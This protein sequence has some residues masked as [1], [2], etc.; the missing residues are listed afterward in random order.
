MSLAVAVLMDPI[1]SIKVAKD[2]TLAMLLEAQRRGHTL[3]YMEQGDLAVR[4]GKAWARMAP[5]QVRDDPKD[6]CTLG[7]ADWRPLRDVDIVLERKD[8]P[9]DAQFIY[10][11]M[12][13]ELAEREGVRVV[14]RPQS[15]RDCNEKL[16]A[17]QFP[18]C[19]APTRVARDP[20]TLREFVSEHDQVVLKP[21]DG[22]GGRG[23]FRSHRGD[24][25]L[26][27][28]LETLTEDGTRL[29]IAQRYIPEITAG[30]KRIL[31]IDGEPVPYALARIPQG[32]EFRG[33]LAAGGRGEGVP[34]SDRDRWIVEQV[35][36]DLRRRGLTFV[37]LDVIGDY[38]TE[39]NVTS[40]TCIREL[41]AQF[42][43]TIAGLM[44]DAIEKT[45]T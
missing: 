30:D 36:P 29:A 14:N 24:P 31:V 5:L 10:D 7:N 34:L 4:D 43:L 26:N 27:S 44:F 33:N 32:D 22:M 1:Q 2:S 25:N 20:D 37:G 12:V 16:Y 9:V 13:L 8:P 23:I 39:I 15:L 21:L 35:A 40:P 17:L 28:I 11:S 3:L 18:Q 41:D 19:C 6:W 42:G 45:L 38:L